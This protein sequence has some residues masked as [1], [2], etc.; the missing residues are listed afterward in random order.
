[1]IYLTTLPVA[2]VTYRRRFGE[3]MLRWEWFGRERLWPRLRYCPG[4]YLMWLRETTKTG[5]ITSIMARVWPASFRVR[6]RP[7]L[8]SF[9][10]FRS[11]LLSSW[12]QIMCSNTRFSC[13]SYVHSILF[14]SV[15]NIIWL[16]QSVTLCA[17]YSQLNIWTNCV[18]L[19]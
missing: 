7:S 19:M 6:S 16:P 10:T 9:S 12:V 14:L 13:P 3:W 8:H 11:L 18:R 4:I 17:V 1:M 15:P 2:K 5:V